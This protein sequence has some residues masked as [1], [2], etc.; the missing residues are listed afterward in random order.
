VW[1]TLDDILSV[2]DAA[3]WQRLGGGSRLGVPVRGEVNSSRNHDINGRVPR[4]VGGG[5]G[6][7]KS[8]RSNTN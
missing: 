1:G 5:G 2:A 8:C 6:I 4:G 7:D 3:R